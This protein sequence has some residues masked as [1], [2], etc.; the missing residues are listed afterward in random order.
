MIELSDARLMTFT[1]RQPVALVRGEGLRVWDSDGKEYL[2]FA[3]GTSVPALGPGH[4]K[5]VPP[6]RE[7]SATLGHVP[8]TSHSP[9]PAQP[10]PLPSAHSLPHRL[11]PPPPCAAPPP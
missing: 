7:Q 5:V 2:D 1:K 3:G 8:N 10:A 11:R 4:P 6:L 9:Q